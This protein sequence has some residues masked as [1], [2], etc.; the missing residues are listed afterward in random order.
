MDRMGPIAWTAIAALTL[1]C[2]ETSRDVGSKG[3]AGAGGATTTSGG[4][5]ASASASSVASVVAATGAGGGST[6]ACDPPAPAGSLYALSADAYAEVAPISMCR[7]R[8]D[9]LLLVN[10]AAL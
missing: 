7:Y 3:A 2:S 10:T 1:G 5:T 4:A 8:G 6:F 9:V